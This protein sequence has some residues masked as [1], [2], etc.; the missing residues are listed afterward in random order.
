MGRAPV[1][2]GLLTG[3]SLFGIGGALRR[4]R[5]GALVAAAAG[6][7]TAVSASRAAE[8]Q[9]WV[10]NAE[11]AV[12]LAPYLGENLGALGK[13]AMDADFGRLILA[14][15]ERG[16]ETVVELGSGLSTLLTSAFLARR[17][18]G[19]L[20]SID[21]DPEFGGIT[22]ERVRAAGHDGVVTFSIA[23]LRAGRFGTAEMDWYDVEGVLAALPDK[24]IDLLVIDGPPAVTPDA[25][26]P[27]IEVLHDRL[28]PDAVILLDDGRRRSESRATSRWVR[29]HP[30]LKR[31]WIDTLKGTWRLERQAGD[32]GSG[33]ER[34][35]LRAVGS[36]NPHPTGFGR[37]PVRR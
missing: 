25:R 11:D 3:A 26:W 33:A 7:I 22:Q 16:P 20:V 4:S 23:P 6:A 34:A 12:V 24:A 17:G 21:H 31:A 30:D 5:E 13:W 28:A 15:L 10:R 37:W 8:T 19:H 29:E 2:L 27:A 35:L 36:V 1:G 14:E 18:A 32:H 9:R